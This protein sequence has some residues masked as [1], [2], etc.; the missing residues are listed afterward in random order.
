M[1]EAPLKSKAEAIKMINTLETTQAMSGQGPVGAPQ[2]GAP[3][4]PGMGQ[5]PM[6]APMGGQP[7]MEAGPMGGGMPNIAALKEMMMKKGMAGRG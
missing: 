4:Q 5:P 7:P 3:L 6:A 1:N 2:M